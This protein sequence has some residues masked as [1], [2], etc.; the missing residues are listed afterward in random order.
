MGRQCF[1]EGCTKAG[2]DAKGAC[3]MHAQR[4]RRYGDYHFITSE[5]ERIKRLREAQPRLGKVKPTTYKKLYGRHEHRVVAER[6]IGRPLAR[7][8]IVHHK[9]GNI[10]NNDPSNL[11]VM[12][13][14]RHINEHRDDLNEGRRKAMK[15]GRGCRWWS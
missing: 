10:H 3:G 7:R 9:D 4:F 11:E 15:E 8:E 13:Q 1:I 14:S 2:N 5:Q 6:V 12:T